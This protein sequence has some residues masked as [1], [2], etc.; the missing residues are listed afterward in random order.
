MGYRYWKNSHKR[1]WDRTFPVL[2][3]GK[4]K[5][6]EKGG[7][8]KKGKRWVGGGLAKHSMKIKSM[9]L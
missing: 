8:H 7:S 6:K 2:K 5:G 3:G 9:T 1:W 4:K